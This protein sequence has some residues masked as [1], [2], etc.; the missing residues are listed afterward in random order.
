MRT[1]ILDDEE[2]T[3]HLLSVV[4]RGEGHVVVPFTQSAKA[5]VYLAHERVDLL[6]TDLHMPG[7]DGV[8]VVLEARRLQPGLFTLIVTGHTSRYAVEGLLADGTADIIFKPFRM[9]E[10]RAR[11]KLTERRLRLIERLHGQTQALHTV[12]N[13]RIRDLQKELEERHKST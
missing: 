4:C 10:L 11:L 3:V 6:I 13:E 2:P 8:A 7:P 12:S 5:L 1:L 9:S